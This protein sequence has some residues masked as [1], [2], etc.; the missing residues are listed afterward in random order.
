MRHA[1]KQLFQAIQNEIL[2]KYANDF[3]KK[4]TPRYQLYLIY[5]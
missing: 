4:F 1:V 2:D 5:R 3:I